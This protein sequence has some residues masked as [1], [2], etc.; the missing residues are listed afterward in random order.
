MKNRRALI[1]SLSLGILAVGFLTMYIKNL[2]NHFKRQYEE[3]NVVVATKDILRYEKIDESMIGIRKIPKPFVQPLAVLA[4]DRDKI[5]GYNMA[6]STIKKGEQM[7]QTK[8]ALIG[9]GGIS[10]IIPSKFRAC[11]LAVDEIS[12]VGG[13]IRNRD[14][15]DV[16][17]TFR[18]ME[19]NAK[20]ANNVESV[21]LLQ[22]IPVLAVGRNYIFDRPQEM[23][24]QKGSLIPS[25]TNQGNNFSNI[26]LQLTPRQCM[27]LAVASEVGKLTIALRSYHDRFS[28]EAADERL[29]D[30]RSSTESVTGIKN[31][32]ELRRPKWL[33]MRGEEISLVP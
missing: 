12:G 15:V 33:E 9:E 7:T 6:D 25:R 28:S 21:M 17:G 20:V 18:T 4:E 5:I 3:I 24:N 19:K 30:T 1:F 22:N 27:D 2:E 31:P 13:L 32:V 11:T 16:I 10:P 29:K 23:Q 26:T 14:T 8:L